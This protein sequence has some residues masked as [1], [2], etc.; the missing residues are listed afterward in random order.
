MSIYEDLNP[1]WQTLDLPG[2]EPWEPD[3]EPD[4]PEGGCEYCGAPDVRDSPDPYG[5]KVC[6]E[7]CF[8]RIIGDEDDDPEPWFCMHLA[9]AHLFALMAAASPVG[10]EG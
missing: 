1:D 3:D 5:G 2:W 9:L 6:C 8:L 7:L 10:G 4:M